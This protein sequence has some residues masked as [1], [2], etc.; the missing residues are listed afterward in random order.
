MTGRMIAPE[1]QMMSLALPRPESRKRRFLMIANTVPADLAS[2]ESEGAVLTPL[3]ST[4]RR[5][6]GCE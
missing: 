1:A 6:V 4:V 3:Q 2:G 5:G